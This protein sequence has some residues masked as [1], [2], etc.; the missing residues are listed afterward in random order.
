[1][2]IAANK[3]NANLKANPNSAIESRMILLNTKVANLVLTR[4]D[5]KF[6]RLHL[7]Q[8]HVNLLLAC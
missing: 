7:N 1:M 3:A 8:L 4:T 6:I 2:D 5:V